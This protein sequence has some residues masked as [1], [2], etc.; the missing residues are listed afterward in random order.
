MNRI[1]HYLKEIAMFIVIMTIFANA[2]SIYKS[3]DL[4]SDSLKLNSITLINNEELALDNDKP[5]L[6]HFWATWC[7]TCKVEASNIEFISKHYNVV[8]IAVNSGTDADI[9]KYLQEHSLSF[10]V[11]NDEHSAYASEFNIAAYPTTFIYDKN[12]NLVFS[13]VGYTSTVGLYLRMWWS[14]I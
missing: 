7:P 11:V 4:N 12:R 6:I 2:I 10:K 9:N 14:E 8:T 1:K 5:L 13:E 3:S